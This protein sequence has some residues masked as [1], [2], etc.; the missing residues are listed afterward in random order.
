MAVGKW[1][2][3]RELS[4]GQRGLVGRAEVAAHLEWESFI[5]QELRSVLIMDAPEGLFHGFQL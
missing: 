1:H 3:E 4:V 2:E 5:Q